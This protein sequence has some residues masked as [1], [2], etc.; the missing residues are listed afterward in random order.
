[1][2]DTASFSSVT[3]HLVKAINGYCEARGEKSKGLWETPM[4]Q[5]MLTC[6]WNQQERMVRNLE[7]ILLRV[8]RGEPLIVVCRLLPVIC[9]LLS[10]L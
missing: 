4:L 10:S 3:T 6:E 8:E 9:M 2:S 1:M 5:K 7:K